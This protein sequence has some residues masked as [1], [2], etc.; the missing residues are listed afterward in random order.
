VTELID[1]REFSVNLSGASINDPA[2]LQFL[3]DAFGRYGIPGSLICFEITETVAIANISQ[4]IDFIHKLSAIGCRFALDDFGSGLSSFDYL[5]QLPVSIVKIDGSFVTGVASDPICRAMI[6]AIC[7]VGKIM[8]LQTVAERVESEADLS[9]LREIGID[10]VQGYA[11]HR[12]EPLSALERV[13]G[14]TMS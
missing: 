10:Y 12:P 2:F 11:V 13:A 5:R 1:A 4:A 7:R 8:H 9:V 14:S 3:L 6:E